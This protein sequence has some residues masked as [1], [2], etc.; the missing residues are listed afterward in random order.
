MYGQD[1]IQIVYADA[2][3]KNDD[4]KHHTYNI[5]VANPPYSVKG[6]L[7]TLSPTDLRQYR[8]INS[9]EEKS[10]DVNNAIETFFIERAEQLLKTDGVAGIILPAPTIQQG[11]ASSTSISK[12][13]YVA[14]REI[15]LENFDI[16]AI[17][18]FGTGTFGKTGTNTVTLFLRRK[19]V[20]DPTQANHYRQRVNDWFNPI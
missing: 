13:V 18:E 3:A 12:N 1:D 5:L 15:I 20:A 19:M 17:A 9:I 14:T 6:F 8:L 11:K 10:F 16:V 2:L 4:I 7:D